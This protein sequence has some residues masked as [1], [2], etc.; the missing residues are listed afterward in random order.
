MALLYKEFEQSCSRADCLARAAEQPLSSEE[1]LRQAEAEGLKLLRSLSKSGFY[2][3]NCR[4]DNKA[5]PYQAQLKLGSKMVNLGY[6]AVPEA[7]ALCV[8]RAAARRA[9]AKP[10]SSLS[11]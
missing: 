10:A 11:R 8:A 1:A 5:R 4:K 2:N 7:A 9:A 3:V 6:F